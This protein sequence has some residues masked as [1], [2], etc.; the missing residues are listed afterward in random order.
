MNIECWIW[1]VFENVLYVFTIVF[2]DYIIE[3]DCISDE[4]RMLNIDSIRKCSMYI[5]NYIHRLYNRKGLY[6][7]W[8]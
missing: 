7:W 5:H 1:T 8:I 6:K 3:N 4:Y 2:T